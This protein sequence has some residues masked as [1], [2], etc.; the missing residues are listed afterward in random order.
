MFLCYKFSHEAPLF[1]LFSGTASEWLVLAMSIEDGWN[2][3]NCLRAIYGK[4]TTLT[5][6]YNSGSYFYNCKK[7]NSIV[8]LAVAGVEYEIIY[9]DIGT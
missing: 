9:A 5:C 1:L 6:P 7:W 2:V 8:V 3:P 4:H